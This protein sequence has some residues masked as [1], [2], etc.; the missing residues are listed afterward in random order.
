M[1]APKRWLSWATLGDVSHAW[2]RFPINALGVQ[3][4]SRATICGVES[5][6]P[7]TFTTGP[8]VRRC[9]ECALIEAEQLTA[10]L[11]AAEQRVV[12]EIVAYLRGMV[13]ARPGDLADYI[14]KRWGGNRG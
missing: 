3:P 11:D 12:G 9:P 10:L 8:H 4:E 5:A 13:H 6:S 14:A 2:E 1:D 7:A